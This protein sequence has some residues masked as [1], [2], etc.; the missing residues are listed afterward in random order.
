MYTPSDIQRTDHIKGER[1][2]CG[3]LGF[4][5][6]KEFFKDNDSPWTHYGAVKFGMIGPSSYAGET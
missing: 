3:W 2:Y 1:P 4:E 6:G 5:I